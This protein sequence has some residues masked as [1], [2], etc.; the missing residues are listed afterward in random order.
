[1]LLRNKLNP[2]K[3]ESP[4]RP[5]A[6]EGPIDSLNW[7]KRTLR[8]T[9]SPSFAWE[10]WADCPFDSIAVLVSHEVFKCLRSLFHAKWVIKYKLQVPS[11]GWHLTKT[12]LPPSVSA[13]FRS[14][15]SL[16]PP[17]I[18]ENG[19]IVR[20]YWCPSQILYNPLISVKALIFWAI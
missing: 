17:H 19:G 1:M 20:M 3:Q 16:T 18:R 9:D 6:L 15:L 11:S 4:I 2:F 5:S 13:I 8:V 12:V 7:A 10:K 14:M